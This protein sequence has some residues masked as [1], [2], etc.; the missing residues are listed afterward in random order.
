MGKTGRDITVDC[1]DLYQFLISECRY[2]YTRNNH[3]MPWGAFHHVYEYLPLMKETNRDF[4]I[5]TACQLAEEAIE[6]LWHYL[7]GEDRY[8]AVLLIKEKGKKDKESIEAKWVKGVNKF[9]VDYKFEAVPNVKF[10]ATGLEKKDKPTEFMSFSKK[11]KKILIQYKFPLI[12][13]SIRLCVPAPQRGDGWYESFFVRDS[14]E[15][16][17]PG[18]EFLLIVE[19]DWQLDVTEY[20]KFIDYCLAMLKELGGRE[21]YNLKDY[22]EFLQK[23]PLG[24]ISRE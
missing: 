24:D 21:P 19:K 17:D 15:L 9:S 6:Q 1:K 3:L 16:V 2:G 8:K 12:G 4:A 11:G 23:H 22:E 7:W 13:Y 14:G 20:A 18:K 10:Y 5:S